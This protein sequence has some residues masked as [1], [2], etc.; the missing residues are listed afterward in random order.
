MSGSPLTENSDGTYTFDHK[1]GGSSDFTSTGQLI[2]Q[3]DVFGNSVIT[4]T[5]LA[6]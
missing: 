2:S 6:C 1:N 3:T 4:E 5:H